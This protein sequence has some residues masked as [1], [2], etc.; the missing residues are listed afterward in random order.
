M[1]KKKLTIYFDSMRDFFKLCLKI[2]Y[3]YENIKIKIIII[4]KIP[5]I[6]QYNNGDF[7]KQNNFWKSI[8]I[9]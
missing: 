8:Q 5:A 3:K 7:T 1:K 4:E 9:I 6:F 2:A